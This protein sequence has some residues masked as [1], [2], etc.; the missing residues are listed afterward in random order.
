MDTLERLSLKDTAFGTLSAETFEDQYSKRLNLCGSFGKKTYKLY[1]FKK[2]ESMIRPFCGCEKEGIM[3][4]GRDILAEKVLEKGEPCRETLE[5]V[6][7]AIGNGYYTIG[8]MVSWSDLTVNSDGTCFI[9]PVG[10]SKESFCLFDPKMIDKA[11]GSV[12]PLFSLLDDSIPVLIGRYMK[13]GA[14]ME[15]WQVCEYQ[16]SDRNPTLWTRAAITTDGKTNVQYLRSSY[17]KHNIRLSVDEK[18]FFEVL[19]STVLCWSKEFEEICQFELPDKRLN[20]EL[21]AIM[22]NVYHTISGDHPHYGHMFYGYET[23]DWFPPT[24]LWYL[25]AV[26]T[27]GNKRRARRFIE[28]LLAC[29]FNTAGQLVYRQGEEEIC[30][31]SAS[32]YAMLFWLFERIEPAFADEKWFSDYIH[33]LESAGDILLSQRDS[34]SGLIKMCAEADTNSRVHIYVQN[35]LWAIRGLQ[36]LARL[37]KRYEVNGQR[38][39]TAADDLYSSICKAIEHETVDTR[40]GKLP[41]F[42]LGY[43]AT[44]NTLSGCKDTFLPMTEEAYR[45]Y[46]NI[47]WVRLDP[48][49]KDEQDYTENT[50][51]NYRYYLEMLSSALLTGEQEKAIVA[52]RR[53]IGGEACGMTR[54]WDRIDDWPVVNYARYL[55][56]SGEK[57]RYLLLFYAHLLHHGNS[58]NGVYY[59]QVS[60]DGRYVANDCIPS[61]LTIPLMLCWMFVYEAVEKPALQLLRCVPDSWFTQDFTVKG[62]LTRWGTVSFVKQGHALKISMPEV[63]EDISIEVFIPGQTNILKGN[64]KRKTIEYIV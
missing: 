1:S 30:G 21:R 15:L 50:Y 8:S 56:R 10:D 16:D 23:H 17:A 45:E 11:L 53:S 59:E 22:G 19:T 58:T 60:F 27:L 35:N 54:L 46:M 2:A 39:A 63:P 6:F 31:T 51:A 33:V 26:F 64:K 49:N 34:V 52:M 62:L 4:S 42:R 14:E 38:F 18:A 44:P 61:A 9:H 57:D 36:A 20:T 43:P 24:S 25:E 5:G 32:E 29:A 13:Q 12:I 48:Q 3:N 28:H 55:L 41:P 47:S 40:F 37:L 7:P